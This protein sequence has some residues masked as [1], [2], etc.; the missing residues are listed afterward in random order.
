M[1]L[2]VYRCGACESTH[3][4]LHRAGDRPLHTVCPDCDGVASVD[5]AGTLR[6]ARTACSWGDSKGYYDRGL[7]LYVENSQHRNRICKERNLVPE[8]DL[9]S[10]ASDS[11]VHSAIVERQEHTRTMAK[12]ADK[13]R[14]GTSKGEALMQ[15]IIEQE[16]E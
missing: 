2:A 13:I 1:P 15:T 12:V 14:S 10:D 8:S 3:E 6:P 9:R 11:A 4:I 7:G 16:T 5:I